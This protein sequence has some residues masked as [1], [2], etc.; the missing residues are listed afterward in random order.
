MAEVSDGITVSRE[1]TDVIRGNAGSCNRSLTQVV[2]V[3]L[4]L[5]AISQEN[6]ASAQ[7]TT[8]S[9]EKLN[10]TINML[11]EAAGS[12]KI[13]SRQLNGEMDFFQM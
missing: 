5:S 7:E 2:A 1:C 10:A 8:A 4:K 11:A 6:A 12:L 9:M 13:L 3:I